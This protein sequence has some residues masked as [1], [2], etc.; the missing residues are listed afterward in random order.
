MA[1]KTVH[2][3]TDHEKQ[4][5]RNG[6]GERACMGGATVYHSVDGE[7]KANVVEGEAGFFVFRAKGGSKKMQSQGG[8]TKKVLQDFLKALDPNK[9]W[10]KAVSHYKKRRRSPCYYQQHRS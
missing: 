6:A 1:R 7:L 4:H 8:P 3:A 2:H 5:R 9:K 10:S